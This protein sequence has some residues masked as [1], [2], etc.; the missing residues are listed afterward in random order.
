MR[1]SVSLVQVLMHAEVMEEQVNCS[2][3]EPVAVRMEVAA[4]VM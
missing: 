1:R 4:D 3:N 2:F